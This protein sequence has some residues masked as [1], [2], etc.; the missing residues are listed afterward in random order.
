MLVYKEISPL[1]A[2]TITATLCVLSS[3]QYITV[4]VAH[5]HILIYKYMYFMSGKKTL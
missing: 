1:P 2:P 5:E 4:Y 3:L